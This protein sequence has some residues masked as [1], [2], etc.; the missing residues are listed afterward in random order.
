MKG[1]AHIRWTRAVLLVPLL[2]AAATAQERADRVPPELEGVGIAEQLGA[3]LPLD[4]I[5]TDES[6][7]DVRLGEY[8]RGQRPVILTLNYYAC[9]T[10]CSVQLNGLVDALRQLDWLP[11]REFEIVTLSFDPLEN[12]H[13]A[14]AKKR[15]YIEEYGRREAERGWHFLTGRKAAIRALTETV[16]F[17]Y[18]WNPQQEQW[19]H[20]AALILCTPEGVVSRYLG[21]VYY[22]PRTLRL[23]LV[24]ASQGR[25]GTLWDQIF[26]TCFHYV[27]SEGRYVPAALAIMR[28]GGGATVAVLAVAITILW[29][30]EAARRR[31]ALAT[32]AGGTAR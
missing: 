18:R 6:G 3:R 28:L 8:F 29:R 10:L 32:A 26:L 13:L 15:A 19:A 9:P 27:S 21:G 5:F 1:A 7:T 25:V 30:R 22:E 14:R 2:A 20:S 4:L 16:G 17:S 12:H 31:T 11:S 24:E 23:S